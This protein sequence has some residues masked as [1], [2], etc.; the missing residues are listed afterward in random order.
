MPVKSV[1]IIFAHRLD[2][3]GPPMIYRGDDGKVVVYDTSPKAQAAAAD[4]T[5]THK[6]PN[7]SFMATEIQLL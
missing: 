5:V 7:T 3:S 4:L 2:V 1:F 6:N